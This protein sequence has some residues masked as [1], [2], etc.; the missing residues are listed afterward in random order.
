MTH[1][2]KLSFCREGTFKLCLFVMTAGMFIIVS[3]NYSAS[4]SFEEKRS[5]VKEY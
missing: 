3:S 1:F 5:L 2:E 4:N